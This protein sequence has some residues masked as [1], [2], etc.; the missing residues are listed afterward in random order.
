MRT[1]GDDSRLALELIRRYPDH[2]AGIV[3]VNP[4]FPGE[5]PAQVAQEAVPASIEALTALCDADQFCSGRYGRPSDAYG[6]AMRGED[7]ALVARAVRS[8][9]AGSTMA[10]TLPS[11][12]DRV[13]A[14]DIAWASDLLLAGAGASGISLRAHR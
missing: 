12:L 11:H 7:A 3:L 13:A 5:D 10:A 4:S 6:A 2:V 8:T 9:L 14:G 1:F